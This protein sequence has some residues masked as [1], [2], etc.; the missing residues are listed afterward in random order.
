MAVR[1]SLEKRG[2][3]SPLQE[4]RVGNPGKGASQGALVVKNPLPMQERVS[5]IPAW[6]GK[7]P[8][9]RKDSPLQYSCLENPM[10]RGV[11][12]ATVHSVTKSQTQWK[13][14]S[15]HARILSSTDWHLP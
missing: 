5:S 7:I 1:T 8:W 2:L 3:E 12:W 14:L 10:D 11:W 6:V 15:T 13:Q 9:R 4:M